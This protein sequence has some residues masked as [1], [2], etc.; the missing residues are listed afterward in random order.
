MALIEKK[1]KREREIHLIIKKGENKTGEF[2]NFHISMNH[3]TMVPEKPMFHKV[4]LGVDSNNT[5]VIAS[6]GPTLNIG[7][8]SY[9]NFPKL[10]L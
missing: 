3:R 1:K 5:P 4:L 6:V 9:L 10:N 7:N 8:L 2:A